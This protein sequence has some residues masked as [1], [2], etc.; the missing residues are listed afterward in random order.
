MVDI[1]EIKSVKIVPFTLMTSSVSAILALIYAI[2]FLLISGLIAAILPADLAGLVAGLGIAMIV[3]FP[4]GT[5]LI[6]VVW[7]FITAWL[8][9]LLVPRVG[10]IK[11]GMEGEE[12][13]SFPVVSLAL[14]SSLI[15]TIWAFIIGL[16]LTA[17]AAP[18]LG[19]LSTLPQFL[20]AIP[21]LANNT[22][23][24]EGMT[25]AVGASGVLIAIIFIIAVPILVFV[26]SF[27]GYALTAVFYNVLIPK[28]GGIQLKLAAA[29]HNF[30]EI[31]NIPAVPFALAIAVVMAVWGLLQGLLNLITFASQGD[32]VGG[33]VGLIMNI[34]LSFIGAFIA[35]AI[36]ALLYN[37]LAPKIGGIQLE[38]E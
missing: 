1:K 35:Y 15:N 5:F 13:K 25:A 37:V 23:A 17:I 36:M 20:T 32:P 2:I 31:T 34:I 22:T 3:V 16:L 8:Y 21:E 29:A 28:V 6:N 12:I 18:F 24:I 30:N 4:I 11:L 14:I 26:F 10:G 38:L 9:N 19:I 33:V 27:I 7:A